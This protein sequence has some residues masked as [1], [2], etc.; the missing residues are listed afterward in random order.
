VRGR[1]PSVPDAI[2]AVFHICAALRF[3]Y[4]KLSA[5]S[6]VTEL[7]TPRIPDCT[8]RAHYSLGFFRKIFQINPLDL[9][10]IHIYHLLRVSATS[11]PIQKHLKFI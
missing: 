10:K 7:I 9:N 1:K 8:V 5:Y 2:L 3:A 6:V 11:L 4:R